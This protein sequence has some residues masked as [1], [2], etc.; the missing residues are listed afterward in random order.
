MGGEALDGTMDE[1]RVF[2]YTANW[3]LLEEH[4]DDNYTGSFAADR[5]GQHI[6]GIRYIDDAVAR[7]TL[8]P[9]ATPTS[10][11]YHYLTDAQFSTVRVIS[12]AGSLV[13]RVSYD[14]YGQARHHWKEDLNNDGAYTPD[15]DLIPMANKSIGDPD[16]NVD[17]D[18]NRDGS[19]NIL[20]SAL[21]GIHTDALPAGWISDP[22]G[23]GS[24]VGFD[25]YLLNPESTQYLV[26][27]RCYD[28]MIG[29][30]MQRDPLGYVDGMTLYEFVVGS[31]AVWLD[32]LGLRRCGPH[33][34][35]YTGSWCASEAVWNAALDG[36]AEGLIDGAMATADG[37][38]PFVDPFADLGMYD[39]CDPML[40]V[41]SALGMLSRD[42]L[43]I[44]ALNKAGAFQN[45]SAWK[46][47]P[48]MYE[49][50]QKR[51]PNNLFQQLQNMTPAA[52]GQW[53]VQN[54]GWLSAILPH[55]SLGADLAKTGLTPGA[56]VGIVGAAI[57]IDIS[58]VVNRF[59]KCKTGK[60]LI[61]LI[62]DHLRQKGIIP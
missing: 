6:W 16:Y 42:L 18:L 7:R 10:V 24:S 27:Y 28:A 47:N 52:R 61:E 17:A 20:D 31:P 49:L 1:E 46:D 12:F 41:S 32:P 36:A 11:N 38:I 37:F 25:G 58:D 33:V 19:V 23:P 45:L 30:W 4:I 15:D 26:R 50:G 56:G 5:K 39:P 35:L 13:E 14:A 34:W 21:K 29:R 2:F 60:S 22:G 55:P 54:Q 44:A 48:V 40:Q 51:L 9:S 53:L 8:D 3:Q 59:C 62:E 57:A 43:L